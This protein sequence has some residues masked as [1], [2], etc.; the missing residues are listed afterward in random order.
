MKK[1]SAFQDEYRFLSNFWP[2]E[3]IG[4]GGL[5]YPTVEHAY[6]ASKS[7]DERDWYA[8]RS[9][10]TPGMA[11]RMGRLVASSRRYPRWGEE[12]LQIMERLLRQK[13]FSGGKLSTALIATGDALLVEGNTWGD[14]FWGV[15]AGHGSNHLGRLLMKIRSEV[16]PSVA[17]DSVSDPEAPAEP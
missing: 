14:T 10:A 9:A 12:K 3:V 17:P 11:K 16:R 7:T 2:A 6:Q 5:I 4:P 15:C 8:I 13:F 1:I